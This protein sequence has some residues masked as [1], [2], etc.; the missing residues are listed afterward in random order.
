MVSASSL[1]APVFSTVSARPWNAFMSLQFW[2][3]EVHGYALDLE[4]P[5]RRRGTRSVHVK[6]LLL[7]SHKPLWAF[8]P[9]AN[10]LAPTM[11]TFI[12]P[13]RRHDIITLTKP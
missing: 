6:E 7:K 3:Q 2:D 4:V 12:T 9:C 11:N 13:L 1:F 8:D 10:S 5:F